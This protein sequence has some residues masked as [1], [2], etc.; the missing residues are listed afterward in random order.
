MQTESEEPSQLIINRIILDNFKSYYGHLE[1]GPFHH[2]FTSIVGPNGSGK[3]NLIESLLFVFGKKASWMRLQKIH[4]LIHNSADHRDVKKA[5]VEVQ[6]IEQSGNN[7]NYFSVKRTVH[8]TGQSNYDINNKHATLEEVTTLLK[9]KG[10][11]LTNNRFLILQGE[12][13]QISLMKPKSGDPE[14]PG[15]LEYLEDIIGS[16][17]YQEQID[18]MT[19]EYLQLDVQRREKG[20]MMRVVEMDL[21][22]LE[23]GKD[24]AV[25]LVRNEIKNSQLQNVQQQIANY[26]VQTQITKCKENLTQI[27]ENQ[28][29]TAQESKDKVKDH[30]D[31]MKLMKIASDKFQKAK[32]KR[33]QI[34]VQLEELQTKDTQNRDEVNNLTSQQQ[35]FQKKLDELIQ[36]R[37]KCIDE[38]EDLKKEIPAQEKSIKTLKQ[39]KEELE[40]IVQKMNQQHQQEVRKLVEKKSNLQNIISE[41]QLQRNQYAKDLDITKNK[42]N[43]LKL[44]ETDGGKGIQNS[45]SECNNNI[46]Q[47]QEI[48]KTLN[49]T[50][51]EIK[52]R[53]KLQIEKQNQ[54]KKELKLNEDQ[55]QEVQQQI[56]GFSIQQNQYNEQNAT[57]RAIMAAAQQGQLKG[58]IGRIGD[59]A[60]IDPKYDIAISTACGKGFDSILVENQQSAEACVN[61][62][63]SNRI[64]RYTFVSLDVVNKM[65]TQD[66][67][68]KRGQNP[69]QTERLFDLIQVKKSEYQAVIFKIVG[70]TLVCDNIDLARKLKFEQRNPNRFVT[71][72]GKLI[73]ANGVM[74]GGGQQRRGA[75]SSNNAKQD[76]NANKN[77]QNQLEAMLKQFQQNRQQIEQQLIKVDHELQTLIKDGKII[78]EKL[79]SAT[80]D[81]KNQQDLKQDLQQKLEKVK[82]LEQEK[83]E[84]E[85]QRKE[86]E[87]QIINHQANIDTI[88]KKISKE[89]KQL[90]QI[91]QE[92][93]ES[94]NKELKQN[95]EKLQQLTNKFDKDDAEFKKMQTRLVFL[96]KKQKTLDKDEIKIK[97][98]LEKIQS[99]IEQVNQEF[100][101]AEVQ[102]IENLALLK[103]AK[104]AEENADKEYKETQAKDKEFD[105]LISRLKE[106]TNKLKQE[107]EECMSL[108][109]KA[110]DELSE[111]LTKLEQIRLNYKEMQNDYE[112]LN[113]LE[114]I[115]NWK[116]Q[117]QQHQQQYP[118]T[119]ANQNQSMLNIS[120][121]DQGDESFDDGRKRGATLAIDLKAILEISVT[122]ELTEE[123]TIQFCPIE[124]EIGRVHAHIQA[125]IREITKDA[126]IKD[127]QE[128]KIKYLEYKAKKSDFDQT[129]QQLQQQKQ[130]IDQ[131][132][133]ER[134]DLFMHGFN[135]IGSKLRETY[136]T[137]TNG[138]DAELELVDTMDPFS[139]GI[140]F[141]VRPKNKSWKQMSKLSGGEKTLSSL[142]LIFALHYY[143][144]TPLYFFDEVDAALDYKNVSIVANFIKERTKNAQFIV[145]SLRNNMFELANKLIGIYKTFD[146]TKTVQIQPELVQM[147]INS[148]IENNEN[149]NQNR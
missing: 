134:Y 32:Q 75:L 125:Q 78:Q 40:E 28:K 87:K 96:D 66:M 22:K 79:I 130:K 37:N 71:L 82:N 57:I 55:L 45:I 111:G 64:G 107:K 143:K 61:F 83:A 91:E 67:M 101:K 94:E 95:K 140:S 49:Q 59:L 39:E 23:P 8:H 80:Q 146:T 21:E 34:K 133:K 20:E 124:K 76:L 113:E 11:D 1:I 99:K 53:E 30:A 84:V 14:K 43:Q 147:K 10:I 119:T 15:L 25:E 136:Q 90:E 19:E 145:I 112:F 56:D 41:P 12:V 137:L 52:N 131:L 121:I 116:L 63:K 9:S 24:K 13:E 144:P 148:S 149:I 18:K 114:E 141:S 17:Q 142:S 50:I 72:D 35:R 81:L 26:K 6:F 2:Q 120:F 46:N 126:N 118:L 108:L 117:D 103:I 88:D 74:S 98:D 123:Q 3:S 115:A 105:E 132:K 4:Q 38:V 139:E 47:L 102:M 51:D 7:R 85:K 48:V 127:I 122:Q 70:Q 62:L 5:S 135:V 33:Q 65:I 16:N 68:Q 86:Y 138:G 128:F 54:L 44:P 36:E 93:S 109:K 29:I 42:L 97:D 110:Q 92:I 31:T 73:E 60:Y 104:E 89:K 58:V 77:N 27:E 100:K 69:S 106:K 129:K